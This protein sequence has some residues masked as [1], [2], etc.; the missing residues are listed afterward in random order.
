MIENKYK[1]IYTGISTDWQ[2]RYKEHSNNGTKTAKAL[3]GKGPLQIVFCVK[4]NDQTDAMQAEIWVKK[5]TRKKKL[6]L[7]RQE[8]ELPFKHLAVSQSELQT[9][10]NDNSI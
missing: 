4:L 6:A 2:R 7:I 3:K 8:N 9:L 10:N 5:Q 1:Q